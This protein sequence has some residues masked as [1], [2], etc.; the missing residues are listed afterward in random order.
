MKKY[1]LTALISSDLS[2]EEVKSVQ[3][4]IESIL[5]DNGKIISIFDP[6]KRDFGT[7]VNEKT[8]KIILSF[9]FETDPDKIKLINSKS[10]KE[11]KILRFIIV[12]KPI[13][14][15]ISIKKRVVPIEAILSEEQT[16][17]KKKT[18]T[19]AKTIKVD[20]SDIDKKIE[21]IL[22]D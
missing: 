7:E 3:N 21:E 1:E 8:K 14:K 6:E 20:I 18:E 5:S 12:S 2:E 16:T 10:K 13:R 19:P 4:K 22:K 15:N 11:K 17:E 9:N